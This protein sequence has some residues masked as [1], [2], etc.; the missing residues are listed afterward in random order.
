MKNWILPVIIVGGIAAFYFLGKSRLSK[1]KFLFRGVSFTGGIL[2]PRFNLK[3][4]IQN[5]TTEKANINSLVGT[6]TANGKT[7]ANISSFTSQVIAPTAESI[8][9]V[10]A[11]P[12]AAGLI[13]TISNFLK[14]KNKIQFNFSGSMNIDN[15]NY[16]VNENLSM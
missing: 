5:P 12:A 11:Q 4:G 13:T 3:F 16:P 15:I 1:V 6:L 2:K 14:S 7:V 10:T 8:Y 9:T